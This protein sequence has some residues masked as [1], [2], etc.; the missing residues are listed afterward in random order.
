MLDVYPSFSVPGGSQNCKDDVVDVLE[1][2][3]FNLRFGGNDEIWD[4]ANLYITGAHVAGEE[5]ESIYVFH[6]ARDLANKVIN[7]VAIAKS[8]YTTRDQV[9]DL[10]ITAD[11]AVGYNTDANGCANVR[12]SINSFIGIVTSSIGFG[13]VTSKKSFA[14][15]KFFE[16]SDF[17]IK[18]AG[19]AFQL[20]DVFAPVG[21]VTAKGLKKPLKP[22]ELEVVDVFSD[23]FAS[24]QFGQLDFIDPIDNLQDDVRTV[25]P[26]F[27]LS[28]IHI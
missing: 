21:L 12:S 2:V 9:F 11:P 17:S 22:F 4:A 28:L 6:A 16:V 18:G 26:L 24:W 13:T 1:A 25:F 20:G 5:Q 14:P 23:R 19:Y 10:T 7:N 27:Y 15:A 8:D 3:A